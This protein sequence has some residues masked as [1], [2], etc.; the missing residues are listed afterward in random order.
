MNEIVSR[1]LS[2]W[3]ESECLYRQ[4]ITQWYY[5]D[6][7]G[8]HSVSKV[9]SLSSERRVNQTIYLFGTTIAHSR[10]TVTPA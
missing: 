10:F 7:R 6:R 8:F 1:P 4:D 9:R 3:Q 5:P 2:N